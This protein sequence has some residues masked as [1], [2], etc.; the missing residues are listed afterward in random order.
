MTKNHDFG[1][2]KVS[3]NHNSDLQ[4]SRKSTAKLLK[5]GTVAGYARSA[6]DI[7][8]FE[9]VVLQ[10]GTASGGSESW[11]MRCF[12]RVLLPAGQNPGK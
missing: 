6:L 5:K 8:Q 3:K 12:I 9:N 11:K 4:K 1:A 7:L 10:P 2:S